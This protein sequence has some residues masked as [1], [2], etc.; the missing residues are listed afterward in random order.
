MKR[1][2]IIS[3]RFIYLPPLTWYQELHPW[4][5][6]LQAG[7][8]TSEVRAF[9]FDFSFSSLTTSWCRSLSFCWRQ[10][11]A[12]AQHRV[13][14]PLIPFHSVPT[15]LW[16]QYV[17]FTSEFPPRKGEKSGRRASAL[18]SSPEDGQE[19][20]DWLKDLEEG[21]KQHS[22]LPWGWGYSQ[23]LLVS[24]LPA[25]P[26]EVSAAAGISGLNFILCCSIH[27]PGQR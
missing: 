2:A 23:Q 9:Y 1:S 22:L 12:A 17:N 13:H 6:N 20:H 16:G 19:G 8:A 11:P 3:E 10:S 15:S 26:S 7:D 4:Y 25:L 21:R 27:V 18:T 24:P 14:S 5:R